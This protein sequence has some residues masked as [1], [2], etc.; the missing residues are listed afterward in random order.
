MNDKSKIYQRES[1]VDKLPVFIVKFE[2]W[3]EANK[4]N[5]LVFAAYH[6]YY[7]LKVKYPEEEI[8]ENLNK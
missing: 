2:S 6:T 1:E 8:N 7:A 4:N 5:D 3:L